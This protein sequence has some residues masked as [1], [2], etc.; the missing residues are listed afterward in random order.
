MNRLVRP[1]RSFVHRQKKL[2]NRQQL[3]LSTLCDQNLISTPLDFNKL[4]QRE[5]YTIWK[6]VLAWVTACYNKPY[7]I[8]KITI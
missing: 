4:F 5:A 1:I 7:S 3:A 8:P 6:L 2:S